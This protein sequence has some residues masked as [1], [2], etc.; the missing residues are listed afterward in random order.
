MTKT[1]IK[2][3]DEEF[4]ELEAQLAADERHK[5]LLTAISSAARHDSTDKLITTLEKYLQQ[6]TRLPQTDGASRLAA[7]LK[8]LIEQLL[9]GMND[10]KVALKQKPPPTNLRVER[11]KSGLIE[12]VVVEKLSGN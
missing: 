4:E 8:P 2:L 10:L 1:K 11:N 9:T 5:E 12:R 7:E 6:L 3:S